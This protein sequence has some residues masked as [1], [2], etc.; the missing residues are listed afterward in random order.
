VDSKV[1]KKNIVGWVWY[2]NDKFDMPR[3]D[4]QRSAGRQC[5]N[6]HHFTS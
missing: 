1:L 4:W 6:W 3:P 5:C 2:F